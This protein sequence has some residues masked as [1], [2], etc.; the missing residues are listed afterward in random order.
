MV[1][2]G[3][4]AM[5]T[6]ET[7]DGSVR[8]VPGGSAPYF[9]A[10][11]R[12]WGAVALV[13]VAGA[14]L[15]RDA[16]EPLARSGVDV[17]GIRRVPGP[18]LRWH[19]RYDEA[20]ERETVSAERGVAVTTAPTLDPS[21]RDPD[22]LFLGSTD[23]AVQRSVLS[24]AGAPGLVVLDTM[25]HWI[26]DRPRELAA[27]LEVVDVV[28]L[29]RRELAALG[30]AADEA[31]AASAVLA[32]GPAWVVVKRGGAGVRAYA[33][34]GDEGRL[35]VPA[36]PVP[37]VV[38]PTGAGDAFAGGLVGSLTRSGGRAALDGTRMAAA[39]RAGA[40]MGAVAVQSFSFDALLAGGGG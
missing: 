6:V 30:G 22:A 36:V 32:M 12:R 33:N 28:V 34:R 26:R 8:D 20:G 5:D 23:P 3:T 1:C 15:P 2:V 17:G 10:A 39:L 16:L 18:T 7:P 21:H 37:R 11:A 31:V 25:G 40:C 24:Q 9:G 29:G 19:A 38:D 4:V 35:Q 14:D 27:L 13:G